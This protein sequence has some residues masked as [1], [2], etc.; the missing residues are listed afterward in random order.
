MDN[1]N[2]SSSNNSG[3]PIKSR[4]TQAEER[5]STNWCML[6]VVPILLLIWGMLTGGTIYLTRRHFEYQV[7]NVNQPSR[8]TA[9]ITPTSFGEESKA[10]VTP[11]AGLELPPLF[12]GLTIKQRQEGIMFETEDD[13]DGPDQIQGKEVEANIRSLEDAR[14][15]LELVGYYNDYFTSRGWDFYLSASGPVGD[16]EGWK[17]D[18]KYFIFEYRID[19]NAGTRSAFLR[20]N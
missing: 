1:D 19:P 11:A 3:Q 15:A 12:P 6:V 9:A 13:L 5:K 7:G 17:K 16:L 8:S 2:N 4:D 18:E 14:L 10:S 20:Y